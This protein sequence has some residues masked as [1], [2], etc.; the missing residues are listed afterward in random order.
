MSCVYTEEMQRLRLQD[1]GRAEGGGVEAD[2]E[3]GAGGLAGRGGMRWG[4]ARGGSWRGGAVG[5]GQSS[6]DE[7][8]AGTSKALLDLGRCQTPSK[9]LAPHR[10]G[11]VKG[12]RWRR[13]LWGPASPLGAVLRAQGEAERRLF[14]H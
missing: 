2:A 5:C 13:A 3:D 11:A 12:G 1:T 6:G 9:P 7:G 8:A 14:R 4:C 10:G